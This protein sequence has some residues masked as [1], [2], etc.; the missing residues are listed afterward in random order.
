MWPR[1]ERSPET[2]EWYIDKYE[3][4]QFMATSGLP[5][6]T[7]AEWTSWERSDS[8]G[9]DRVRRSLKTRPHSSQNMAR[10][11]QFSITQAAE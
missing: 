2:Q 6:P 9:G 3:Y 8:S 5:G 11:I 1:E 4:A 10:S 7:M